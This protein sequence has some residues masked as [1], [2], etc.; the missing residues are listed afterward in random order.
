MHDILNDYCKVVEN[1]LRV[2]FAVQKF[3]FYPP[4]SL[5]P[6]PPGVYLRERTSEAQ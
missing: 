5:F 2:Y 6:L 4:K 3:R 1:S